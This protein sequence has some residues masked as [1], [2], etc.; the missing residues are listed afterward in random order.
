MV[1]LSNSFSKDGLFYDEVRIGG[2]N[3]AFAFPKW[4]PFKPPPASATFPQGPK[5]TGLTSRA[6]AYAQFISAIIG[7]PL[8]Q[9]NIGWSVELDTLPLKQLINPSNLDKG[10]TFHVKLGD[11]EREY[12]GLIGYF[13]GFP[14]TNA[15][16]QDALNN[17]IA[18]LHAG[19][20]TVTSNVQDYNPNAEL[21]ADNAK[22]RPAFNPYVDPAPP[23]TVD[24]PYTALEGFLMLRRPVMNADP[25]GRW[26]EVAKTAIIKSLIL[27][28][29]STDLS[30]LPASGTTTSLTTILAPFRSAGI[31]A[32]STPAAC[33][34][35]RLCSTALSLAQLKAAATRL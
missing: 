26:E 25:G 1:A 29:S 2:P 24:G 34:S 21:T 16:W 10:Y 4:L 11:K 9:V 31:S 13:D 19:P 15:T 12:D 30:T 3:G 8:A 6:T 5:T 18:F 33:L 17:L 32:R 27:V 20:V 28:L 14:T 22:E 23:P 7:K 35:D